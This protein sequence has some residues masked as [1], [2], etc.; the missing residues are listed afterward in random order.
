MPQVIEGLTPD[1]QTLQTFDVAS[2]H[3]YVSVYLG[4]AYNTADV[5]G[6]CYD[7]LNRLSSGKPHDGDSATDGVRRVCKGSTS[8]P[9]KGRFTGAPEENPAKAAQSKRLFSTFQ[10]LSWGIRPGPYS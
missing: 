5:C 10:S 7:N 8:D 4:G 9:W 6:I 2:N 1:I 3:T